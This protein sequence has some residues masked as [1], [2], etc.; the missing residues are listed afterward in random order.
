LVERPSIKL[1]TAQKPEHCRNPFDLLLRHVCPSC[2]RYHSK[3]LLVSF[4]S[5]NAAS[6]HVDV[7]TREVQASFK[8]MDGEIRGMVQ[9]DARDDDAQVGWW[10]G[11]LQLGWQQA[12]A[13]IATLILLLKSQQCLLGWRQLSCQQA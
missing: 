3:A 2:C 11:W 9:P 8:R 4:D 12:Y 7:L 5:D 1:T 10:L 6:S 13:M